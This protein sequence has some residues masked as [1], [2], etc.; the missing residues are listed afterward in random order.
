MSY[1][2]PKL[3]TSRASTPHAPTFVSSRSL[4]GHS[5]T[6]G[7]ERAYMRFD[8]PSPIPA[9]C[10][11]AV[12]VKQEMLVARTRTTLGCVVVPLRAAHR[13]QPWRRRANVGDVGEFLGA[14]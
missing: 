7:G 9:R 6:P 4:N 5:L 12:V 13:G 2:W 11:E 1:K 14:A 3:N 8:R 10:V